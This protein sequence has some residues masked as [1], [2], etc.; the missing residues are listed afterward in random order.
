MRHFLKKYGVLIVLTC[1][2]T[3]ILLVLFY[4]IF[5]REVGETDNANRSVDST[6]ESIAVNGVPQASNQF[7]SD[8]LQA[9]CKV[10]PEKCLENL[11]YSPISLHSALSMLS[12]GADG[13]TKEEIL[14]ALNLTNSTDTVTAAQYKS[15]TAALNRSQNGAELRMANSI[16]MNSFYAGD[17]RPNQQYVE[18]LMGSYMAEASTIPFSEISSTELINDW[19]SQSTNG[20]ISKI[21][22]ELS[23]D[24]YLILLNAIYM[25]SDW[26][27]KFDTENTRQAQ[28]TKADGSVI[29][30]EMMS[31]EKLELSYVDGEDWKAVELPSADRSLSTWLFMPNEEVEPATFD[32]NLFESSLAGS[33]RGE[34]YVNLPKFQIRNSFEV[35]DYLKELGI[36]SAFD[37]NSADLSGIAVLD[38]YV[39]AVRHL[40]YLAIDENGS[41]AAA[42]TSVDVSVT[43]IQEDGIFRFVADRPFVYTIYDKDNGV[44]LFVGLV[45][46]PKNS[47]E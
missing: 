21:V 24:Q 43:S 25:K 8:Y 36:V 18:L 27:Y 10:D 37:A 26:K 32:Y 4:L 44:L 35:S 39:S 28:F 19:V 40:T 41:E 5:L 38:L 17:T 42:V 31:S 12:H 46:E 29:E 3:L 16:W 30:V 7:A 15:L 13:M 22:D 33:Q 9:V 14:G 11:F 6:E 23:N 47:E 34:A 1:V 45:N 2:A 20:R